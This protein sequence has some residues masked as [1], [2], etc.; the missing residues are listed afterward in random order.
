[1]TFV[2]LDSAGSL[3]WLKVVNVD[4]PGG[5]VTC[6]QTRDSGFVAL[7]AADTG[8]DYALYVVKLTAAGDSQWVRTYIDRTCFMANPFCQTYDDGFVLWGTWRTLWRTSIMRL[9]K[10]GDSLWTKS[11]FIEGFYSDAGCVQETH[12]RG[13]IIGGQLWPVD[14][15]SFLTPRFLHLIRTD[16]LGETLWTRRFLPPFAR[17]A[18]AYDVKQT[19]DRGIVVTGDLDYFYV[20]LTKTDSLG[21]VEVGLEESPLAAAGRP[22]RANPNPSQ[23]LTRISY[24]VPIPGRVLVQVFDVSGRAV[25]TLVDGPV[26]AGRHEA[27]WNARTLA[28][29]VYLIKV[30]RPDGVATEK[31][32]LAR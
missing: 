12:D 1:V 23:G 24:H 7:C 6:L 18:Y 11:Y 32:L 20:Y 16:S 15:N 8:R 27:S 2:K 29:G 25:A 31:L 17:G 10:N 19:A 5:G 22:L 30:T 26:S 9:D 13:F 14:S 3:Q 21:N 28:S 4:P